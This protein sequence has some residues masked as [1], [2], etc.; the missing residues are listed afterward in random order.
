[1]SVKDEITKYAHDTFTSTWTT[2]DGRKVPTPE[3]NIGLG[4]V[5]TKINATILY[6]DLSDST[7]L[8]KSH[9][10]AFAAEVYKTYVYSAAKLIRSAGGSV[11]A[12]DGDRVMGVF[13]GDH[14]WSVAT[15][16]ALKIEGTVED[17]LRPEMKQGWP[18]KSFTIKQKCGIAYSEVWVANTGIRGNNDYVWVGN[19]AN[20]AAKMAALKK[21]YSTYITGA[22]YDVLD[23]GLKTTGTGSRVWTDLGSAD[24]GF[25]IWGANAH[26]SL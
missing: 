5:A 4:N 22:I 8:V 14:N 3:S 9:E 21:S 18:N 2:T 6:A 23:D 25:R 11:T 16:V 24:L 15:R 12:Y 7:G 10:K 19:A 26:I 20:Y 17:I 13:M 1:M